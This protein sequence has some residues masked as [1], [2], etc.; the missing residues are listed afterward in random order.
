VDA[1]LAARL[2]DARQALLQK[3][4]AVASAMMAAEDTLRASRQA[5]HAN[6]LARTTI[7]QLPAGATG[8]F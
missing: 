8:P 1:A 5:F 6:E 3:Q 2:A 4:L 7:R